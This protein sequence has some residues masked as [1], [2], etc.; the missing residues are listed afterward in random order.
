MSSILTK[1]SKG[2]VW[3]L[4]LFIGIIIFI[5][6]FLFFYKFGIAKLSIEHSGSTDLITDAK[7]LSNYL[8]DEGYPFN[9][10]VDNVSLIGIT[11]RNMKL[12]E[13]KL[14]NFSL[15]NYSD[16]K[17]IF[18]FSN[19]YYVFFQD[20]YDNNL[21]INGVSSVGKDYTTEDIDNIIRVT[22]FLNYDS[23]MIRMVVYVW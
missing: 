22:R 11:D 4:D 10:S 16:T 7:L 6:T 14:K 5:G 12:D 18:S 13:A 20:R 17:D 15:I 2:Q 8:V 9:W 23:D 21:T 3:S 19:D 1:A